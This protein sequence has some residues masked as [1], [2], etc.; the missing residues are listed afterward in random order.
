VLHS[1]RYKEERA[2]NNE[3][4]DEILEFVGLSDVR[5]ERA[6]Q[7]PYGRQRILEIARALVTKPKLLLLDEPA[8]GLNSQEIHTLMELI[9]S[10]NERGISVLLIEHRMEVVGNLAD[11]VFVLNHGAKVAEG[12][13]D[14][15]KEDP[16]VIQAYLGKGGK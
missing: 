9:S 12:T 2:H 13:F 14:V 16:A 10:I 15:I 4:I 3:E 7:L 5:N 1:A 6:S 11:W 8:A